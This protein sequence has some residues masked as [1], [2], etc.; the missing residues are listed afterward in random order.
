MK[1]KLNPSSK[2]D[3]I[4][5]HI[6]NFPIDPEKLGRLRIRMSLIFF[7]KTPLIGLYLKWRLYWRY[8]DWN[9]IDNLIP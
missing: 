2:F 8:D 6:G 5:T 4:K 1:E 3:K 7:L 9:S